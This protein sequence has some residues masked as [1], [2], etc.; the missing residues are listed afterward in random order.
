MRSFRP[1]VLQC[2]STCRYKTAVRLKKGY[3]NAVLGPSQSL[4]SLYEY[5]PFCSILYSRN[6]YVSSRY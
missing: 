6:S 3:Q 1:V 5:E 2:A 4:E